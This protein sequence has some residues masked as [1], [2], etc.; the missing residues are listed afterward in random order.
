MKSEVSISQRCNRTSHF[1]LRICFDC[2]QHFDCK[3]SYT[4]SSAKSDHGDGDVDVDDEED[5]DDDT[6]TKELYDDLEA[7]YAERNVLHEEETTVE[8]ERI[9]IGG[10]RLRFCDP[11]SCTSKVTRLDTPDEDRKDKKNLEDN[12]QEKACLVAPPPT[13][14][15]NKVGNMIFQRDKCNGRYVRTHVWYVQNFGT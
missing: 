15:R 12:Q 10:F 9:S 8:A 2:R 5:D 3:S 6:T 13:P 7:M 1:L 11:S 4:S 14:S